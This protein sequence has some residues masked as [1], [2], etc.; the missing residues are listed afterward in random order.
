MLPLDHL[1]LIYA[2]A[3][4]L[5]GEEWTPV[6]MRTAMRRIYMDRGTPT[7]GNI[8]RLLKTFPAKPQ[9]AE[10]AAWLRNTPAFF[11][12]TAADLRLALKLT[13]ETR[14]PGLRTLDLPLLPTV[15]ALS[16]WLGI[17][18]PKLHW[19]ADPAGRNRLHPK[20]PLRTYHY[21]WI[22][23]KTATPRLLEIPKARLK[24]IQRIILIEILN[25]VPAHPAAHGFRPGR[26]IVTNAAPHCG[27]TV[28]LR[29]D[30]TDFFPSI[31]SA[32]IFRLFRTLGYPPL[33]AQL[34]TGL[35]T[36]R[37][38]AAVW[39]ARPAAT[40]GAPLGTDFEQR[41]RLITRHLPQ[42]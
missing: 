32:R 17:P 13:G 20:G 41:Q 35:C 30:L 34:L 15:G 21:R 3:G 7:L 42:G 38:P 6:G 28:V 25:A 5:R 40:A 9:Y 19:L 14:P 12:R 26:S 2:L 18:I 1:R 39:D 37:L 16:S 36:T 29:F 23:R 22:P 24:E 11:E 4:A 10:L 31:T 8:A 27:K 33:V